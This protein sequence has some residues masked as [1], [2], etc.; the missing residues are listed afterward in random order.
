LA[1]LPK[2]NMQLYFHERNAD[3]EYQPHVYGTQDPQ[4]NAFS[5]MNLN[6]STRLGNMTKSQ[7]EA[8]QEEEKTSD[9]FGRHLRQ[10][11]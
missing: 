2:E 9:I 10:F 1:A 4:S 5:A 3:T 11:K 6:A 8:S 7:T